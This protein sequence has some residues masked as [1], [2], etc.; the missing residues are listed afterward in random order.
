MQCGVTCVR[1]AVCNLRN[2]LRIAP[3]ACSITRTPSPAPAHHQQHYTQADTYPVGA[4]AGCLPCHHNEGQHVH[5]VDLVCQVATLLHRQNR[6]AQGSTGQSSST[7]LFTT[8]QLNALLQSG[9]QHTA[10]HNT[11]QLCAVQS[12]AV[13]LSH[14][15]QEQ[16]QQ[17]QQQQSAAGL[18]RRADGAPMRKKAAMR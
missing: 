9:A 1:H 17:Q 14:V 11:V 8:T 2:A 15:T 4:E 16:Q 3:L 10:V 6:A 13:A 5:S 7:A 18:T 12:D